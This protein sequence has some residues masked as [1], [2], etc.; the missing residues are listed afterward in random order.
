MDS[1]F[2]LIYDCSCLHT[3]RTDKCF[4]NYCDPFYLPNW[5]DYNLHG[6]NQLR[7]INIKSKK[8]EFLLLFYFKTDKIYFCFKNYANSPFSRFLSYNQINI[9]TIIR[10]NHIYIYPIYY[11]L[12]SHTR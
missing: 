11:R 6:S 1:L 2:V 9:L 3:C 5:R 10:S 8:C 7:I 4:S 12:K